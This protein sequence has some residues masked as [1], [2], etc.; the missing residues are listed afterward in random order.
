MKPLIISVTRSINLFLS[1][2]MLATVSM[3]LIIT[4][5]ASAAITHDTR[6]N[7]SGYVATGHTFNKVQGDITVPAITCTVSGAHNL[8]WV[9][10]DGFNNP[11]IEQ[12]GVGAKCGGSNG[13]TPSYY[14]WYEMYNDYTGTSMHTLSSATVGVKPGNRIGVV[15]SYVS[16]RYR[17]QIANTTTHQKA[18]S[19]T[20]A[21]ASGAGY[22]CTRN[23]AEWIA[24]R[25]VKNSAAS[26]F[27]PLAKFSHNSTLFAYAGAATSTNSKLTGIYGF[28]N[29]TALNMVSKSGKKLDT[30]DSL[31]SGGTTFGATWY[32]AQ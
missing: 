19:T 24:E 4:G 16:G 12:A 20:V 23:S 2:A 13:K 21:C 30:V 26:Q 27:A 8:Y 32:A 6:W 18:F 15:V 10:F 25:Y 9:G 31:G 14:A 7:W 3:P 22:T 29:V 1:M 11:T 5:S 28:G 17:I